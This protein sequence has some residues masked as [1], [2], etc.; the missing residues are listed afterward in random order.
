[1]KHYILPIMILVFLI[2][3]CF[4]PEHGCKKFVDEF[5]PIAEGNYWKMDVKYYLAGIVDTTRTDTYTICLENIYQKEVDGRKVNIGEESLLSDEPDEIRRLF[6]QNSSGMYNIG[7]Y[8]YDSLIYHDPTVAYKYPVSEGETWS[9]RRYTP[10]SIAPWL[11]DRGLI[12]YTCVACDEPYVTPVDTFS[13]TVYYHLT[14]FGLNGY[15]EHTYEYFAYGIG[16]V[17][18]E[19]YISFDSTYTYEQRS[20]LDLHHSLKLFDYCIY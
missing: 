6:F 5:F 9:I 11:T 7:F 12:E 18:M 14:L 19:S 13:T 3:S 8:I 10:M 4:N 20:R 17:G 16:K 15:H 2:N 1:M